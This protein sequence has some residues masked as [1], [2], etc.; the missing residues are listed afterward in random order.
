MIIE[1]SAGI[2]SQ[3]IELRKLGKIDED[4]ATLLSSA[5]LIGAHEHVVKSAAGN[6]DKYLLTKDVLSRVSVKTSLIWGEK[7]EFV[8]V[9]FGKEMNNSI[10]S[11]KLLIIPDVGHVPHRMK[12]ELVA[13]ATSDF[14]KEL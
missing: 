4:R 2:E 14:L 3:Q 8:P 7:D 6:F 11:S 9:R 1:D 13:K 10:N 12:P 5:L